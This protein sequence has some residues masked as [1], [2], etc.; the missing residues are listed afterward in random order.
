MTLRVKHLWVQV[1]GQGAQLL[2]VR[3]ETRRAISVE[4]T[5]KDLTGNKVLEK[6]T[7]LCIVLT[8]IYIM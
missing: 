1:R 4:G 5:D 8:V 7:N 2:R 6:V 3:G